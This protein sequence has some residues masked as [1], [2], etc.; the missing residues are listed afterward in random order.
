VDKLVEFLDTYPVRP[1][2]RVSLQPLS[3]SAKATALCLKVAKERDWCLSI[4]V[5]KY[6]DAP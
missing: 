3:Q 4:Q 6:I 2:T 5:H 1:D